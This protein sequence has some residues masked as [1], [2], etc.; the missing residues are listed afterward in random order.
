[1]HLIVVQARWSWSGDPVFS[2]AQYPEDYRADSGVLPPDRRL[3][4]QNLYA[5]ALACIYVVGP[6]MLG[7]NGRRR[8]LHL[9][10]PDCTGD[11]TFPLSCRRSRTCELF[12][13]S[14]PP[15]SV[16]VNYAIF[17]YLGPSFKKTVAGLD[18]TEVTQGSFDFYHEIDPRSHNFHSFR[19]K[20]PI[21][22]VS[23]YS[24][25]S[26]LLKLPV[27]SKCCPWLPLASPHVPRWINL[28]LLAMITEK[29]F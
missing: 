11:H 28:S 24:T 3:C 27:E 23:I 13:P 21:W 25:Q 18:T 17:V 6:W 12:Q 1:M 19:L 26:I 10:L 16:L 2:W 20:C 4:R 22:A 7:R 14:S 15:F 8:K 29:A 9:L 5:V